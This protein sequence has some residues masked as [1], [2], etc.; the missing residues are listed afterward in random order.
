MRKASVVIGLGAF[1]L[2]MALMLKFYAYD[3]LAVIPLDQNTRQTVVDDHATFFDA[4]KV[5]PGAGKLTTVATV[6][7][8]PDASKAAS[9]QQGRDLVVINKGQTSDNNDQ[10]PPMDGSTDKIVVDRHTGVAVNCCGTASNGKPAQFKGQLIKFPFQTT[11]RTYDYWDGTADRTMAMKY[12]ST[13]TIKGLQTYKFE[14][15]LPL[16][17]YRT[18]EV[19]RGIFGLPDTGG[20]VAKRSYQN[21]RTLWVEP[22]TGVI[23]KLQEKQH[24]ELQIDEPGAKPVNA[25]T[26][27]SVFTDKT[28][29]DNVDEYASKATLLKILR[30]WAPLALGALGVILLIAGVFVSIAA[31]SRRSQEERSTEDDPTM[32]MRRRSEVRSEV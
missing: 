13:E 16:E 26:T 27:T 21:T 4:D 17:Q 30:F 19:P 3:R 11:R 32:P 10:A 18:Q 28:V 1:F 12:V 8:D 5:A 29:Q 2:T 15:V 20:V 23:I 24:Q 22:E 25:L 7:G 9:K 31:R 14:G 6:I